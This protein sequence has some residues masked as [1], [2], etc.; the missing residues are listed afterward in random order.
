MNSLHN[1]ILLV[2]DD[3]DDQAFFLDTIREIDMNIKIQVANN[4]IEA[5]SFLKGSKPIPSLIFLDL[6]MPLMNGFQCLV[7][8]KNNALLKNIPV[9]IFTTSHN[10][11][12]IIKTE[13]MGAAYF[14]TK[15]F[16]YKIFGR[17]LKEV[18]NTNFGIE[19]KSKKP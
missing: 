2:D 9:I 15:P 13:E 17:K 8:L 19:K 5:I 11:N 4:G 3:E 18:L 10:S 1:F 14:F 16:D 7:E 12:D 6:N